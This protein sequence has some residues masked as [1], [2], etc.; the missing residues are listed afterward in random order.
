VIRRP[1]L[2][3]INQCIMNAELSTCILGNHRPENARGEG[4]VTGTAPA[5]FI[6]AHRP[7]LI[8][9]SRCGVSSEKA[10][11]SMSNSSPAAVT[12]P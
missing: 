5:A 1:H 11:M 7:Q 8:V 12:M 6:S 2:R 9:R 3:K 4:A 10:G